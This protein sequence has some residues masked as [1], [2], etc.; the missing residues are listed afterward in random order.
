MIYVTHDQVEAL[1]L[2]Q[3]VAVLERGRLEQVAPPR[4]L[5][6]R[7]AT[8]FVAGFIGS[9][10][11]A[12]FETRPMRA[13]DGG[14]AVRVGA[15]A[16]ALPPDHPACSAL[17]ARLERPLTAGLRPDALAL[18]ATDAPAGL[19]AVVDF[20]ESLGHET[21][22]HVRLA[23]EAPLA[24]VARLPGLPELASGQPVRLA[25]DARALHLFDETG[26]AVPAA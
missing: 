20:V 9:P 4:A 22:A 6:E 14:L 7:P 3:R 2:G 15:Q 25:V 23:G 13:P 10:P 24:L 26:R 11:M 17:A 16:I 1:T 12:L 18:A 19:D 5:Y 8:A 21:L